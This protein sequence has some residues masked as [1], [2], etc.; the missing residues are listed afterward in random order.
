M[1]N[2]P[3]GNN[4]DDFLCKH[5]NCE[6]YK[7]CKEYEYMNEKSFEQELEALTNNNKKDEITIKELN[8]FFM[9]LY[10]MNNQELFLK[11]AYTKTIIKRNFNKG[12]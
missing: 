2:T 6:Y 11:L 3:C 7:H 4:F 12:L 10:N 5:K 9:D 8:E 1:A